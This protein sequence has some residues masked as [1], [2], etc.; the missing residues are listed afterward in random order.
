MGYHANQGE[1]RTM[2]SPSLKIVHPARVHA[3]WPGLR[4][5]HLVKD[6]IRMAFGF[7]LSIWEFEILLTSLKLLQSRYQLSYR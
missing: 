4:F 7:V 1:L 5:L 6:P 2:L 3:A